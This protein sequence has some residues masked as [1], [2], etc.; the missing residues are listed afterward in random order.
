M[1]NINEVLVRK[2][3][4]W[5]TIDFSTITVQQLIS[6]YNLVLIKISPS[7]STLLLQYNL[8]EFPGIYLVDNLTTI[9][10]FISSFNGELPDAIYPQKSLS[11]AK[12]ITYSDLFG[13]GL[14]A[15]RVAY[16]SSVLNYNVNYLPDICI[17]KPDSYPNE[18]STLHNKVLYTVNGKIVFEVIENEKA[19][20]VKGANILDRYKSQHLGIIDFSALGGFTKTILDT[21]HVSIFSADD[22]KAIMYITLP[23][24]M[25]GKTPL[26]VVNGN[27][28]IMEDI[29]TVINSTQI[30]IKLDY[31]QMLN[32]VS[33]MKASDVNWVSAVNG[34]DDGFNLAT[35]NPTAYLTS[36][37]SAVILVDTTELSMDKINL[38]PTGFAER[39]VSSEIPTGIM[40]LQDGTIGDYNTT[41]ITYYGN[42]IS[43]SKPKSINML[44][45]T[46]PSNKVVGVNNANL[47]F[48]S[49]LSSA[50]IVDLYIL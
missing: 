21:T 35:V 29:Y 20:L 18:I 44:K 16:S 49:T 13:F 5:S 37:T 33:G 46:I 4:S 11:T 27:L 47:T 25:A 45:D 15:N 23:E 6:D 14:D 22:R 26:L 7:D 31:L 9:S 17:S 42:E 1:Y 39:Y 36:G 41:A 32:D 3:R 34:N 12:Y 38:L 2:N 28:R 24:P 30:A 8:I 43:T 40:F 19:Y 50:V 10:N 48:D